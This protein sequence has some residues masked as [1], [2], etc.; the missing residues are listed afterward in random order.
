MGGA[1]T[2]IVTRLVD[3]SALSV[4]DSCSTY[5][6]ATEKHAVVL[7]T[8]A[9]PKVTVPGPLYI[10]HVVVRMPDGR[11]SSLA[12]PV[13]FAQDGKGSVWFEPAL[14]TGGLFVGAAE[15]VKYTSGPSCHVDEVS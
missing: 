11:P 6:P 13:K 4:A 8:F 12:V 15:T 10:D 14:T 7:K 1:L 3:V 2:V 5:V 9:L